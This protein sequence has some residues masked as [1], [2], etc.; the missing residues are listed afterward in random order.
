MVDIVFSIRKDLNVNNNCPHYQRRQWNLKDSSRNTSTMCA[1]STCHTVRTVN[2]GTILLGFYGY[3]V[4]KL[5][6]PEIGD[7]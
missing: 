7:R 3:F 5:K 4:T 6:S 2:A 1:D